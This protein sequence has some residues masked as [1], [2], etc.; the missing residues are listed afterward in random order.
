MAHK[1][2]QISLQVA[3]SGRLDIQL[4]IGPTTEAIEVKTTVS[5][6]NTDTVAQ[7]TV[8]SQEKIVS[9]P[10]NGRQFLQLALLVPGANP[11]GRSVQQN[12]FR[13]GMMAGLSI[14]GGRTNNTNFLLDGATQ[15]RSRLQHAELS[16][17]DRLDS[18]IS[19]PDSHVRRRVRAR[20]R[21]NQRRDQVRHQRR[22]WIG[23][24]VHPQQ[25]SRRPA[26]QSA[27]F[28]YAEIPT[29]PVRRHRGRSHRA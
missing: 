14:S 10:L 24:G 12:A 6:L 7:G 4:Q 28:Q 27:F 5:P 23:V 29:Q 11:G 20:R 22:A 16:A 17:F 19:G 25:R 2:S 8:I 3:Q 1:D 15:P 9:L 21:T 13:Q 18:G 26:F